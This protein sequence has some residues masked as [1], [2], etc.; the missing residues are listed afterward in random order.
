MAEFVEPRDIIHGHQWDGNVAEMRKFLSENG[1]PSTSLCTFDHGD[2]MYGSLLIVDSTN[3]RIL[4][5]LF[6]GDWAMLF[7]DSDTIIA[8]GDH[9]VAADLVTYYPEAQA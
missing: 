9:T 3:C 1:W 2:S 5:R 4:Q 7:P 6:P 8:W